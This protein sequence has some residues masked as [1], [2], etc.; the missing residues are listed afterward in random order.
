MY[1][2]VSVLDR[3]VYYQD[4]PV[5]H[6]RIKA[7]LEAASGERCLIVP[8]QEFG[9]ETVEAFRPTAVVMSGFG[10][11]WEDYAA[12]DFRGMADVITQGGQLPIL[13]ICGSH[14]LLGF[15]MNGEWKG[16]RRL[17]DQPMRV[18]RPGDPMPRQPGG[19]D[20]A[21]RR[22]SRCF[23]ATG[24]F[25][26]EQVRSDPLFRGLPPRMIM[27]CSH[28][29]EVKRL[30]PNFIRLARSAHC[31][32]EAMRH[33]T[34]P[35]YGVQFHPEAFEAPFMHGRTLLKNFAALARR[36]SGGNIRAAPGIK[37]GRSSV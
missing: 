25:E 16:K 30:P 8:F 2:F 20:P 9:L 10:G 14:Q 33:R 6:S 21:G 7:R 24:F 13:C 26:I 12:S 29:C 18:M 23:V 3:K 32:I 15:V 36:C 31:A 17:F 34:R 5:A 35:L 37:G 4:G 1:L 11:R 28:Y 19:N 22:R 27:R